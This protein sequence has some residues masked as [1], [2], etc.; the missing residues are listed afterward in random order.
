MWLTIFAV[1]LAAAICLSV[2]AR[3]MQ[4]TKFFLFA[5]LHAKP[6]QDI[7]RGR[8]HTITCRAELCSVSA[9]KKKRN[10]EH[11]RENV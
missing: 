4:K 3:T 6:A 1:S 9:R 2:A 7:R 11:I 5:I 10:V 8:A